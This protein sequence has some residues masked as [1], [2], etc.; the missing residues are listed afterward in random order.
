MS[1]FFKVTYKKGFFFY[2]LK[3]SE[4]NVK[5]LD[6]KDILNTFGATSLKSVV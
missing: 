5:V 4:I 6:V 1:D 3:K 2:I